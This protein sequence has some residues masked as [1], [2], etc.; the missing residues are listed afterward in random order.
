MI[1]LRP[2]IPHQEYETCFVFVIVNCIFIIYDLI[3]LE[4]A[5]TFSVTPECWGRDDLSREDAHLEQRDQEHHQL[6]PAHSE[7]YQGRPDWKV[8]NS[9]KIPAIVY[10]TSTFPSQWQYIGTLY[11]VIRPLWF[12]VFTIFKNKPEPL[13]TDRPCFT[14]SLRR[15]LGA[16]MLAAARL[17]PNWPRLSDCAREDSR[18]L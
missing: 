12:I 1:M 2:D 9:C 4:T 15:L 7:Q 14:P 6:P 16:A 11:S 17:R 10:T 3:W 18:S 8:W 5:H 13:N